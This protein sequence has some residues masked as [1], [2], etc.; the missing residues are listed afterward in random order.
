MK[1]MSW[2]L[3]LNNSNAELFDNAAN[4]QK[5]SRLLK[6][7]H[8]QHCIACSLHLRLITGNIN[9]LAD[10]VHLLNRCNAAVQKFDLK[11]YFITNAWLNLSGS[12]Y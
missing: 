11:C 8:F 12:K 2:S 1:K 7:A 4:V 3:D 6:L 9:T 10:L 5:A